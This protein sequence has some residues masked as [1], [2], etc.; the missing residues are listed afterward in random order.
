M[1]IF[2]GVNIFKEIALRQPKEGLEVTLM[3]MSSEDITLIVVK[4]QQP[5]KL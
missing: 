3:N 4:V 5:A 2:L 1:M